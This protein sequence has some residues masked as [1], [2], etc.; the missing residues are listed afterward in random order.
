MIPKNIFQSWYTTQLHPEVQKYIDEMKANNPE[1]T[2]KLY[3]D[4]EMDSFVNENFKGVIAECYNKLNIIV[5]KVD[6]WR[7]LILYKYGDRTISFQS[8]Y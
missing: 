1:Y 7:Y 5:A 2:Y 4:S 8:S 6:F 3:T